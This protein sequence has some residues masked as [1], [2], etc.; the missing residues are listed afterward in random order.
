MLSLSHWVIS[1]SARE[2][3]EISVITAYSIVAFFSLSPF[4][5]GLSHMT[6]HAEEEG[7]VPAG[8]LD[9]APDR[10]VVRVSSQDVEGEPAQGGKVLGS[11]V[12]SGTIVVLGELNVEYPMELVFDAPVAA[13]DLQQPLGGYVLG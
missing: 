6:E 9:F 4:L 2:T 13:C 3:R 12:L 5:A 11:I 7:V 1:F 8:T 10:G